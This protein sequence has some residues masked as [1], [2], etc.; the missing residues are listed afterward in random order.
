MKLRDLGEKEVIR[1]IIRPASVARGGLLPLNDDAQ[2]LIPRFGGSNPMV[3]TTDRTPTDLRPYVW[4]I[5]DHAQYGRYSAMSN[6]SDIAAMGAR[7]FGYLLNVAASPEMEVGDFQSVLD[8][9]MRELHYHDVDLLG[10]DTKEGDALNLVG[11]AIGESWQP[12]VLTRSGARVGDLLIMSRQAL[13]GLPAAQAYFK[14]FGPD[15]SNAL[16]AELADRFH[17]L[18][19]RV[20]ESRLLQESGVCTS[21]M[22]NSDGIAACL[23]EI[24]SASG[25][26]F[27]LFGKEIE[28][29]ECALDAALRLEVSPLNLALGAGGDLRLVATVTSLSPS[30][31]TTFVQI[32][33]VC[34]TAAQSPII[35]EVSRWN[36]FVK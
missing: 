25:V 14:C 7:P 13:G 32:G 16:A 12:G 15:R 4:G 22:D 18:F 28:I 27:S 23:D 36:H 20:A 3:I 1:R 29:D 24:G 6:I 8:G 21:C 19:A 35:S 10:G 2:I 11:V 33:E 17:R 34:S 31:Q 9:V 26:G 30:L 5:F